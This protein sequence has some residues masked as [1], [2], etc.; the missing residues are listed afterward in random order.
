MAEEPP[1]TGVWAAAL[2]DPVTVALRAREDVWARVP[3][4]W[5]RLR[6]VLFKQSVEVYVQ[7]VLR[8]YARGAIE[9]WPP[10]P[11]GTPT[12]DASLAARQRSD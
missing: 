5:R 3:W 9:G 4:W 8:A 2:A 11:D 12:I 6:R 10:D 1:P 7:T